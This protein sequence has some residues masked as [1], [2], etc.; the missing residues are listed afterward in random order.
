MFLRIVRFS[1]EAE[2]FPLIPI[3]IDILYNANTVNNISPF[4][5]S[6]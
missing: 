2:I 4:W 5:N 6:A 3:Q 1:L